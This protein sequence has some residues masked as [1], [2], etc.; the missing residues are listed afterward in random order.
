MRRILAV[1][2][3]VLAALL[4]VACTHSRA[5]GLATA[6]GSHPSP[7]PSAGDDPVA[8]ARCM[9]D[10]GQQVPDPPATGRWSF[11]PQPQG[12][13][14]AWHN[15]VKACEQYIP[16]ILADHGPTAQEMAQLRQFAIC[17][18][19]HGIE[20]ADPQAG[21]SRPGDMIISGRLGNLSRTQVEADPGYKAAIAACKDKLPNTGPGK[22]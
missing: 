21:G 10:H 3:L 4:A 12:A 18:R 1:P 7:T 16:G 22:K 19:A 14:T 15:A 9:R 5:P 11:D 17:M 6:N 13:S 8:F 2:I 20:M